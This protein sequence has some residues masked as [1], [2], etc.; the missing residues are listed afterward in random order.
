MS[1]GLWAVI[2]FLERK[3]WL[4]Y[5]RTKPPQEPV[6][7][8]KA[9]SISPALILDYEGR[10]KEGEWEIPFIIRNDG[11]GT[12][13]KVFI[14]EITDRTQDGNVRLDLHLHGGKSVRNSMT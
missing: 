4:P 3:S 2:L 8:G 10:P 6:M 1:V 14:R 7:V 12:A 11:P 9:P 13:L 5:L